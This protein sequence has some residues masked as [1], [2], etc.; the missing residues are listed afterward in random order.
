MISVTISPGECRAPTFKE[1]SH[2]IKHFEPYRKLIEPDILYFANR[3]RN[4]SLHPLREGGVASYV[5]QSRRR[6]RYVVASKGVL[7]KSKLLTPL[8]LGVLCTACLF[9]S[10]EVIPQ[11]WRVPVEY[12]NELIQLFQEEPIMEDIYRLA[13]AHIQNEVRAAAHAGATFLR[14]I[15][16][17]SID[18]PV[19]VRAKYSSLALARV[20]FGPIQKSMTS[21]GQPISP[22][23]TSRN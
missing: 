13:L 2:L 1:E 7:S 4:P 6:L 3:L 5:A 16:D 9:R 17:G 8:A 11:V 14:Q 18:A 19:A 20:G 23:R 21:P 12:A 15:C 10:T 22:L